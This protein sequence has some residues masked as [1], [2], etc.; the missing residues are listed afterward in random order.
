MGK[1]LS[2]FP[3][4][5]QISGK[6]EYLCNAADDFYN[7]GCGIC[8]AAMITQYK[9]GGNKN[10]EIMQNRGVFTRDDLTTQWGNASTKFTWGGQEYANN[11][12]GALAEIKKQIDQYSD[13]CVLRIAGGSFLH[14]VT[15]YGYNNSC[16][17]ASDVLIRDPYGRNT[18]LQRAFATWPTFKY[19]KRII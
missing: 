6:W 2:N 7:F 15:V 11:L 3:D 12:N 13:P 16:T 5:E 9:E 10:P 8:C 4:Y 19:L 18:N 1:I 17:S 14:F